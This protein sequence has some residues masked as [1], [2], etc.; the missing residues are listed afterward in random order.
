MIKL[1][2]FKLV[3]RGEHI[4]INP[5]QVVYVQRRVGMTNQAC[6]R[7]THQAETEDLVVEGGVEEAIRKLT[8]IAPDPVA[9][10]PRSFA[11][12]SRALQALEG[13]EP[14]RTPS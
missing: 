10:P 6:I 11:L 1:V 3:F 2:P 4:W 5:E 13:V 9:R 14:P 12:D 8:G 7:L